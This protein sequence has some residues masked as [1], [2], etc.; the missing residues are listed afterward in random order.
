MSL[1]DQIMKAY[2]A[3]ER[4]QKTN[5]AEARE[6]LESRKA[7]KFRDQYPS[8]SRIK[9]VPSVVKPPIPKGSAKTSLELMSRFPNIKKIKKDNSP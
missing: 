1:T 2:L 3:T 7:R 8:L 9:T 6:R 5:A 4:S